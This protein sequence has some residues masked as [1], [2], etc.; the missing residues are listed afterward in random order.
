VVNKISPSLGAP[1]AAPVE[2][3]TSAEVDK[4]QALDA[5]TGAAES[6]AADAVTRIAEDVAAGRL[7]RDEA[8]ERIIGEALGTDLVQAAPAEMRA[9]IA[10]ALESLVATDPYLQSLVRGLSSAPSG[11]GG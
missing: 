3:A 2:S 9:E 5:P 8:V 11:E 1:E 7:S 4:A 6:A 10:A